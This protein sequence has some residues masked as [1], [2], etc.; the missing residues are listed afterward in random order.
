MFAS[1]RIWY[2]GAIEWS[3]GVFHFSSGAFEQLR[4]NTFVKLQCDQKVDN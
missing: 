2:G 1:K 3:E 4:E